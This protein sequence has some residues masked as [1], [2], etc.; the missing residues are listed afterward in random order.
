MDY[1]WKADVW[2]IQSR[3]AGRVAVILAQLPTFTH[4]PA[5]LP[6]VPQTALEYYALPITAVVALVVEVALAL[7]VVWTL[8]RRWRRAG[9]GKAPRLFWHCAYLVG[10]MVAIAAGAFGISWWL[11]IKLERIYAARGV[12]YGS[13]AFVLVAA[14]WLAVLLVRAIAIQWKSHRTAA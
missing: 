11:L 13:G 6:G 8:G 1:Y 14:I 5:P 9:M 12:V 2:A 3:H 4:K 10:T 7:A